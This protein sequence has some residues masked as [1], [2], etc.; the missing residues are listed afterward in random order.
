MRFCGSYI[1]VSI[2]GQQVRGPRQLAES[3]RT[4]N[5]PAKYPRP[6]IPL[7]GRFAVP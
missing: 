6:G 4:P 7:P 3:G 2:A 1:R 5:Y